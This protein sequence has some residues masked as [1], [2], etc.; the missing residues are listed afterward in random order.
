[1]P[2]PFLAEIERAVHLADE[3]KETDALE[4]YNMLDLKPNLSPENKILLLIHKG[5]MYLKLGQ[6]KKVLDLVEL[7]REESTNISYHLGLAAANV[8]VFNVKF[9]MGINQWDEIWKI[10]LE[11]ENLIKSAFQDPLDDI[12]RNKASLDFM[13]GSFYYNNG[14]LD[15]ASSHS[16][17][18]LAHCKKDKLMEGFIPMVLMILGHI[19][20]ERGDLDSSLEYLE[21]SLP[22]LKGE[23]FATKFN[24]FNTYRGIAQTYHK[25]GK[26]D[27]AIENY[28]QV[29]EIGKEIGYIGTGW[30]YANLIHIY[31]QKRSPEVAEVYLKE[32]EQISKKFPTTDLLY[33]FSKARYLISFKRM[34]NLVKAQ[35]IL[36]EIVEKGKK[37]TFI[38]SYAI[39]ELCKLHL[40][41]LQISD[42]TS[43][44]DETESLIEQLFRIAEERHSFSTL[45]S[46]KLL[47]GKL[48]LIQLKM[49]DARRF[50]TEGQR[51]ADD[52][53]ITMIARAISKEHDK[54]L[55]QLEQWEAIGIAKTP[56]S[57]RLKLASI[58]KVMEQLTERSSTESIDSTPEESMVLLIIAEGGV[59]I[60]SY[61]FTVEWKQDEEL[62]SSFLSAFSSFSNEFFSEGLDRVKFG[63]N[64]V[65]MQ[66]VANFSVCYLFKGQSYY[67][68]QKLA[69]F[70]HQIEDN[71]SIS[72]TLH[73]F[74]KTSQV[75]E[76]KD[77]PQLESLI[78]EIFAN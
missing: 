63:Q 33:Q 1:M 74:Y 39:I 46:T 76:L 65:L 50:L 56:I 42:D 41:E 31:L 37:D 19:N 36:E 60:F 24:R 59:L 26:F 45:A 8:L 48:S 35:E 22:L 14:D 15:L 43:I 68:S 75:L 69:S 62:F 66:S 28:K 64:T 38:S 58:N 30:T 21:Q 77:S 52:H 72:Q 70:S 4:L 13:K 51:I 78:A 40:I 11:T 3:G 71:S 54:L 17:R 10:I 25:Q 29:L 53:G 20:S 57:E 9:I 32:F 61:P 34:K 5:W 12:A 49:E 18:S 67:A 6:I 2:D 55:E 7:I 23:A 47:Q 73:K 27:Q 44:L 16:Q